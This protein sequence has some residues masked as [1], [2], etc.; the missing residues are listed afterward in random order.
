MLPSRSDVAKFVQYYK[1]V[2]YK[3][4]LFGLFFG[5]GVQAVQASGLAAAV[6]SA[7][8]RRAVRSA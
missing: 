4:F 7:M 3:N 6:G 1:G 8:G 5:L 2:V